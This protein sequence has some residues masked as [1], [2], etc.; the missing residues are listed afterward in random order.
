TLRRGA[1]PLPP[2]SHRKGWLRGA[3]VTG[4]TTLPAGGPN[5]AASRPCGPADAILGV[6]PSQVV[7][8]ADAAGVAAALQ[9]CAELGR[10]VVVRGGGTRLA[11]GRTPQSIDVVLEMRRLDGIVRY[12]PGDLTV[13]VRAGTR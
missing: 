1:R 10:S 13:S 7:E 9:A 2:A 5:G 8:P 11:W 12:E 3:D 6:V 4:E